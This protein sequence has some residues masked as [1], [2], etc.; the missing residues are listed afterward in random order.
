MSQTKYRLGN[1]E[2][3]ANC[4]GL[5]PGDGE[6]CNH[7]GI[8]VGSD[9]PKDDVSDNAG[10][11]DT[12]RE[13]P[14]GRKPVSSSGRDPAHPYN[15]RLQSPVPGQA[16]AG[17][18]QG[19][20]ERARQAFEDAITAKFEAYAEFPE[21]G[22]PWETL[23]EDAQRRAERVMAAEAHCRDAEQVYDAARRGDW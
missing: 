5:L 23:S 19:A 16:P 15:R 20:L 3:C 10:A 22:Q 17:S 12:V 21:D 2:I 11:D 13:E 18:R 9:P 14:G 4:R 6:Y 7:C 1:E 8:W